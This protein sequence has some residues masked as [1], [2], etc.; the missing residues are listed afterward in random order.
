MAK[1]RVAYWLKG[2]KQTKHETEPVDTQGTAMAQAIA[3][4]PVA[5]VITVLRDSEGEDHPAN[6]DKFFLDIIVK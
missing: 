2:D 1:Y 5:S 4:R 6:A 3:L